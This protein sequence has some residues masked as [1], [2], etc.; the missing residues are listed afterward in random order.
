VTVPP[1]SH[2]QD[3]QLSSRLRRVESDVNSLESQVAD[4]EDL[5]EELRRLRHHLD[6]ELEEHSS[7]FRSVESDVEELEAG[8]G[9]LAAKLKVLTTR[10][11]WLEK[12]LASTGEIESAELDADALGLSSQADDVARARG[13]KAQLHPDYQLGIWRQQIDD[14]AKRLTAHRAARQAVLDA[15]AKLGT[16]DP[17]SR[18]HHQAAAAFTTAVPQEREAAKLLPQSAGRAKAARTN[19]P[20]E[21]ERR[22]RL[23]P[24]IA[25]GERA[26]KMLHWQLRSQL[27]DA[28]D[29]ALLMP[30][31]FST[32]FGPLPPAAN[33]DT[34][35][36]TAVRVLAHRAV[37]RITDPVLALGD[38]PHSPDHRISEYNELA[39]D[40]RRLHS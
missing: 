4:L 7:K 1:H 23:A 29:R 34:W 14:H 33:A 28:L 13:A 38:R 24:V 10:L 40:L 30:T 19:L 17:N 39:E 16:T 9:T 36:N 35:L 31:W 3:G 8:T 25:D 5:P 32:V 12:H 20:Q 22:T 2:T 6:S 21:E 15:A 27:S 37:Y 11:T 18:A 26:E